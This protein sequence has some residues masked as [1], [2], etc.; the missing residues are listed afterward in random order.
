NSGFAWNAFVGYQM[1]RNFALEAG[2]QQFANST[3]DGIFGVDGANATLKQNSVDLIGKLM[4]PLGAGFGIFADG[5]LAYTDLKRDTNSTADAL[6]ADGSNSNSVRPTYGLGATYDFYPGWS[7][8]GEWNRI[9][10]GGGIESSGYWGFGA[11]YH[12]G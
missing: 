7:V 12:F 5:G 9:S 4:L 6:G 1:N 8:L 3:F 11:E 2:Y 10:S